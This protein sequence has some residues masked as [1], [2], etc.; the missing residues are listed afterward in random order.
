MAFSSFCQETQTHTHTHSERHVVK[1]RTRLEI[2][3]RTPELS[4]LSILSSQ[5]GKERR[6]CLTS[7]PCTSPLTGQ[8]L[9]TAIHKIKG[10]SQTSLKTL[11]SELLLQEYKLF[12]SRNPKR[13]ALLLHKYLLTASQCSLGMCK[14]CR[15][16][17]EVQRGNGT[18]KKHAQ[19]VRHSVA[20]KC[21]E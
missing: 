9:H 7:L 2:H 13:F 19:V 18:G 16:P 21:P 15:R 10:G 8:I 12:L 14:W 11:P 17:T 1:P 6:A 3:F 20:V 5:K 4:F